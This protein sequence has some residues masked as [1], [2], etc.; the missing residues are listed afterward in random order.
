MT[1]PA[2]ALF[3]F[4]DRPAARR[5]GRGTGRTPVLFGQCDAVGGM[6]IGADRCVRLGGRSVLER[7]ESGGVMTFRAIEREYLAAHMGGVRPYGPVT[8]R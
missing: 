1:A 3:A 5:L 2:E 8:G 6:A 4:H 7:R